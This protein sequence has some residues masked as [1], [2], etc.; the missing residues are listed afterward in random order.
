MEKWGK[1]G[2]FFPLAMPLSLFLHEWLFWRKKLIFF[3][4]STVVVKIILYFP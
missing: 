2:Y 3:P 1:Q 4:V